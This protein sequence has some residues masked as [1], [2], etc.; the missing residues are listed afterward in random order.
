M[1]TICR[2][3][4]SVPSQT[5][6]RDLS[7]IL[8]D[9]RLFTRPYCQHD[10][11]RHTERNNAGQPCIAVAPPATCPPVFRM[12]QHL[13]RGHLQ[14]EFYC[15]SCSQIFQYENPFDD[16]TMARPPCDPCQ[17][18]ICGEIDHRADCQCEVVAAWENSCPYKVVGLLSSEF[19]SWTR[20]SQYR[21]TR[22]VSADAIRIF[23]AHF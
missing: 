16:R 9:G 4:S 5:Y 2:M 3:R 7:S 17:P 15:R 11:I 20:P 6:S 18:P 22:T 21:P 23:L 10:L 13:Y 19:F 12:K 8:L 1:T 14:P